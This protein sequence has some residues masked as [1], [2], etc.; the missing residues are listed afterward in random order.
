MPNWDQLGPDGQPLCWDTPGLYY[1]TPVAPLKTKNMAKIK[2][3]IYNMKNDDE[4]AYLGPIVT[5]MTGNSAFTTLASK[6]TAL[7]T[8]VTTGGPHPLDRKTQELS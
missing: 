6:T 8:A 7:G 1:D 4:I 3:D 5:K 2:L